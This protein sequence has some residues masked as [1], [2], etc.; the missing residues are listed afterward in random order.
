M[1][2][3]FNGRLW[4]T[5][6]TMSTVDDSALLNRNLSVG[7]RVAIIAMSDGGE[8]GVPIVIANPTEGRAIVRSDEASKAIERAF[9]PSAQTGA[10]AEVV[11]VRVNP[12]VQSSLMLKDSGGTDV[13]ELK[14]TDYGLHTNQIKVKIESGTN[15]GKKITTQVGNSYFTQDDIARNAFSVEY[16]GVE[17]T[18]TMTVTGTTVTLHAPA[19]SEVASIDLESYD[20]VQKLVDYINSV[21]GFAAAVLDGNGNRPTLNG[22]DHVTAQDVKSAA[23]T[24]TADLQAVVDWFNG[25][26]EGFVTAARQAGAGDVPANIGFTYLAGGSNGVTTNSDWSNALQALQS[27]D[28]QWVVALSSDPVI[29]AMVDTHCAFMSGVGRMERRSI[30]GTAAGTSDG[31][32][33]AAAKALNSDRSSIT[34]LGI[35]DYGPD[36][37]LKL[38]PPYIAAAAMAGALAGSNPGTSL[39]NKSLKIRGI[40][41]N[42]RNPTDTD[43]LISGGVLCIENTATGYRVVKS[44]TTWLN[45]DN[46]NRVEIATGVALDFTARNVRNA[47]DPLRGEKGGPIQMARAANI[48]ESTLRELSRPEPS[49]PGVLV[50]DEENPPYRN[51]RVT[52]EGDVLRIDFECSPVIPINYIPVTIYAV[53]YSGSASV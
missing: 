28:V 1:A 51:I 53:P 27:V 24:A 15:T 47:V 10:P 38:Y 7:N 25:Q 49:G 18:A 2:V 23:F 43:P 17:T 46:Y 50:G 22:L 4:V 12:A 39:T 16:V 33:I 52:L 20:T 5:P 13:I 37:K 29:H 44:I 21:E 35:Y 41:R 32:A 42:L 3:F 40:E 19:G 11:F 8:P 31:D 36:G 26:S 48:T 34:H 45:D 9:D 6:A 30:H 14:S